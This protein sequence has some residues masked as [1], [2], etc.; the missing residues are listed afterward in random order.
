VGDDYVDDGEPTGPSRREVIRRGAILLGVGAW[1]APLVHVVRQHGD[2][3]GGDGARA[4]EVIGVQQVV[5]PTCATCPTECEDFVFCA[6]G[7]LEC[8]C[9][10]SPDP[11]PMAAC[12]CSAVLFCDDAT[13]C[14]TAEDCPPG[15][16]CLQGCCPTAICLP[17]CEEPAPILGLESD[18]FQARSTGD[19]LARYAALSSAR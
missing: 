17:P 2:R 8:V 13:E 4:P 11:Y 15:Q 9:V 5:D 12:V 3:E 10:P 6:E 18:G 1:A 19:R 16:P 14:T 7:V